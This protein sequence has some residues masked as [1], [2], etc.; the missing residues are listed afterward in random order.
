MGTRLRVLQSELCNEYQHD[1][2][3]MVLRKRCVLG[4]QAK[5]GSAMDGLRQLYPIEGFTC[6]VEI[7]PPSFTDVHSVS[8]IQLC[9]SSLEA[10]PGFLC[11]GFLLFLGV[12]ALT[13]MWIYIIDLRKT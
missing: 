5:V 13:K 11:K 6:I 7:H 4:L 1:R 3:W 12:C 2:A 8:N 10:D 9:L